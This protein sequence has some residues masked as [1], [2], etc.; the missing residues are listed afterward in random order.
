MENLSIEMQW[1][2]IIAVVV[3]IILIIRWWRMTND[4]QKIRELLEKRSESEEENL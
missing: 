3:Y 1:C 2:I 4:V